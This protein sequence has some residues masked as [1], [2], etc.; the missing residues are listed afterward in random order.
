MMDQTAISVCQHPDVF[1]YVTERIGK[2]AAMG[3]IYHE[4]PPVDQ[5]IDR[6]VHGLARHVQERQAI[7]GE[8]PRDRWM[9]AARDLLLA[10]HLPLPEGYSA[11]TNV[12]RLM[13]WTDP[14]YREVFIGLPMPLDSVAQRHIS[15]VAEW[16]NRA[17]RLPVTL[18]HGDAAPARVNGELRSELERALAGRLAKD[19]ELKGLF[20]SNV[21]MTTVFDT[22]PR[23]DFVWRTGRLIV[24]VD[25][26][27]FHKDREKFAGDRQRDYETGATGYVTL[28]LTDDEIRNDLTKA[29]QKVRRFVHLR[30][31]L[32]HV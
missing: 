8:I 19:P 9:A 26:Y 30:R 10:G 3:A 2:G 14:N 5:A 25:S 13:R 24:E 7:P 15:A 32:F 16:M 1:R 23:V 20:E 31:S 28:R 11:E 6:L 21:L 17:S 29:V 18:V 22:R 27:Y 4:Y 12:D